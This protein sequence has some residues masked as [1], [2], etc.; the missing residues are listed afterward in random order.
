[1]AWYD[2]IIGPAG[3]KAVQFGKK[4][5]AEP[6]STTQQR[7]DL[8]N[9]GGMSS[10]FAD[11]AQGGYGALGAE[12]DALRQALRDQM[13]GKTSVS[14]EMLRQGLDQQLN[15]GRSMAASASPANSGMAARTAAN[16][17]ARASYGMSGQAAVA[18]LQERMAASQA[19]ADAILKQRQQD[20]TVALGSRQNAINAYGGGTPEKSTLEK[21][22]PFINA[23]IGAAAGGLK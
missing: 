21:L 8:R 2:A 13:T 10:V 14:G 7:Q 6:K 5:V 11:Q 4:L 19:L 3:H 18:G 12:G 1:M 20:M 17:M 9:Q 16:N 23:G 15:L 22:A